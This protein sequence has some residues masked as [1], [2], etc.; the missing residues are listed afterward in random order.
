M[1]CNGGSDNQRVYYCEEL[2]MIGEYA[3]KCE[4]GRVPKYQSE[5][6]DELRERVKRARERAGWDKESG[7][8][9]KCKEE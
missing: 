7:K 4:S 3:F 8:V 1:G 9:P 5:E 2:K 6:E